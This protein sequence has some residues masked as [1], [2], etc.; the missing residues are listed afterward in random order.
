MQ[1]NPDFLKYLKAFGFGPNKKLYSVFQRCKNYSYTTKNGNT[2]IGTP[3]DICLEGF[4]GGPVVLK[5]D[6]PFPILIGMKEGQDRILCMFEVLQHINNFQKNVP[7]LVSVW[8]SPICN[9][10]NILQNEETEITI[11]HLENK[12]LSKLYLKLLAL[13]HPPN[14]ML[15]LTIDAVPL[16]EDL[17]LNALSSHRLNNLI[18]LTFK[19]T[20]MTDKDMKFISRQLP[21]LQQLYKLKFIKNIGFVTI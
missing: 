13:A 4:I 12:E 1:N 17:F 3:N 9:F 10:I 21:S 2:I 15:E 5:E 11:I 18:S 6:L 14:I 16:H 7:K 8:E 19:S 20:E